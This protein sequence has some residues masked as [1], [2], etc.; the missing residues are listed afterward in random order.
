VGQ[1][2]TQAANATSHVTKWTR[3]HPRD[4]IIGDPLTGVKTRRKATGNFCMFVNFVS[5][6]E[7]TK[8]EEAL[9]DPSWVNDLQE[10]LTQFE[11]NK[12]WK[13]VPRPYGKTVIG[14]KWVYRNKMD[15]RGVVTRNK[16]RLVAMGYRQEEGIDYDETFA[17]M[18]RL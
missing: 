9:S 1:S 12:V 2:S 18:A 7:P 17:P 4:Q 14:T 13:L 6:V 3:S 11:R 10:E 5:K 15:E 16:A 8:I